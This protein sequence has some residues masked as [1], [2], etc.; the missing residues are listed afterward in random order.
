MKFQLCHFLL[1]ELVLKVNNKIKE[2]NI[3]EET[4]R[5]NT[6]SAENQ[7]SEIDKAFE[8]QGDGVKIL[9][10]GNSITRH[11][12]DASIGWL[13][14]WGMA[15]SEI[16]KDY[17]HLLIKKVKIVNPNA[18]FLILQLAEWEQRY[19]DE[20]AA[21]NI[22]KQAENF[23]A[24]VIISRIGENCNPENTIENEFSLHYDGLIKKLNPKNGKVIITTCFWKQDGIDNGLR[25]VA[26]QNNHILIELGELESDGRNMALGLFK[27]TGIQMHPGDRGMIAIAELIWEKLCDFL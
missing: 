11:G 3:L 13:G 15:A 10:I 6:V 20:K 1:S 19:Q 12:P 7:V 14:D 17:V 4:N 2:S 21:E 26:N 5:K 9:I 23:G 22:L 27:H 16:E 25:D 24:D 8:I 18:Q